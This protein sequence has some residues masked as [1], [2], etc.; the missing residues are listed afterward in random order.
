MPASGFSL[1]N[2]SRMR[3][4]TGMSRSARGVGRLKRRVSFERWQTIREVRSRLA[5]GFDEA[6]DFVGVFAARTG[7]DAAGDIDAVGADDADRVGDLFRR[8]AAGE[9]QRHAGV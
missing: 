9:D 1:A 4:R 7:L 5:D 2:R 6:P 8:Q 3:A